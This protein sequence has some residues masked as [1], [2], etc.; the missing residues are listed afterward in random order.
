MGSM[1][2]SLCQT[3]VSEVAEYKGVEETELETPLFEAVDPD[4]LERLFRETTGLVTFE[5]DGCSVTV[6][7]RGTVSVSAATERPSARTDGDP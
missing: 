2:R 7:H 3:V 6:D 5:Y 1:E 4:A